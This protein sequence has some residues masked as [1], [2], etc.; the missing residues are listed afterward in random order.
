MQKSVPGDAS[1]RRAALAVAP[2]RGFSLI[3][4]MV[5]LLIIGIA[6]SVATISAF[7]GASRQPLRQEAQRLALLFMAAQTQARATGR[8]IVWLP[9][10]AGY[11]FQ[12]LPRPLSLP[13]RVAA[14]A[15]RTPD[16]G[17]AAD[18]ALRPRPW[19]DGQ[20]VA[21]S[22]QPPVPLRF[23]ADWVHAPQQITLQSG[24]QQV[25]IVRSADGRYQVQP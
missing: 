19:P 17:F 21:V 3:E 18:S 8:V 15:G 12:Q 2:Q 14:R 10:Q 9:G 11:R 7:G 6:A 16:A 4:M 23:D 5:A 1:R 22:L 24:Q 13:S 25:R 20:A